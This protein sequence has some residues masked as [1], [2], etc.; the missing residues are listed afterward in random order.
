MEGEK[1]DIT[2]QSVTYGFS[3]LLGL[4]IAFKDICNGKLNTTFRYNTTTTY[5]LTASSLLAGET[6]RSDI[7]VSAT[8]SQKGFELPF[9]GLSLMNN[10]D[11]S[12]NYSYSNNTSLRYDFKD[13]RSSGQPQG[14][15]STTTI[16]PR[17]RYSL[18]ERVTAALYYRYSKVTPDEGGATIPG[19]TTNEGG[20]DINIAIK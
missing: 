10:I 4:N 16:E 20:L 13:F 12:I 14:G 7:A 9:F 6:S 1:K 2:S 15:T 5:D 11:V 19:S 3:P 8:Y 17:I 18:S